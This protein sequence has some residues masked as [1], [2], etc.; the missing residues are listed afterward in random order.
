MA[1]LAAAL[2]GVINGFVVVRLHV[3]SFI[4]TLGMASIIAAVQTIVAGQSQPLPPTSSAWMGLTQ[5]TVLGFQVVVL[6]L[7]IIALI[8]WWALGHTRPAGTCTPSVATRRHRD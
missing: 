7:L 1:I 6:Y 2:I 5:H 8:L 3:N 4:A